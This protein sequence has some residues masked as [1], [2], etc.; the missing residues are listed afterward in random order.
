MLHC[1]TVLAVLRKYYNSLLG[2]FPQDP[3]V[4]QQRIHTSSIPVSS[5]S[6]SLP[7][8]STKVDPLSVN[9]A[10]LDHF[11]I[12]MAVSLEENAPS[13]FCLAMSIIIGNMDITR[14]LEMGMPKLQVQSSK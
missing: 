6:P 4:T 2:S 9:Q 7:N 8:Q 12:M 3:Y 13:V 1:L 11:I 10:I 5:V 14:N